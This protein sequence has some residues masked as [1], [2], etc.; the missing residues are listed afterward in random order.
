MFIEKFIHF[1]IF[2]IVT[3][4]TGEHRSTEAPIQNHSQ[5]TTCGGTCCW[6]IDGGQECWL[7]FAFVGQ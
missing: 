4:L 6:I 3:S 1:Q 5:T 7:T 2:S